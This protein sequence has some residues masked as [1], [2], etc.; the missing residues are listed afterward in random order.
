MNL[1]REPHPLVHDRQT[2]GKLAL[3]LKRNRKQDHTALLDEAAAAFDYASCRDLW[4]NP[5]EMSLLHGTAVWD[6]AT[7]SQ[8]RLLNQLY[9]VA[10]YSQI[11]SA[12]VATIFFNQTAAAGLYG[13][14][15]FRIVGDTLDLE[16]SQE[17]AHIAAFKDV[18]EGTEAELFGRRLFTWP[19]RGPY[20]E[21]MIF[22]DTGRIGSMWKSLQLR[23]FGLL[24]S[25]NA[26]IASQYL[27]V[28]GL[29]TLNG[30]MVQERLSR[31]HSAK[32]EANRAAD[33]IPSKI[34]YFHFM[35]ESYHFNSSTIIGLEVSR[36]LPEP[37]AFEKRVA[38][39]GIAGCQR[40]HGK[41]SVVVRGLFWH[42]PATFRSVYELL[43]SEHFA[44]GRSDALEL[45]RRTFCQ[46]SDG[47]QA[48]AALQRE[49][50]ETYKQYVDP[51]PWLTRQ[52]RDMSVMTRASV[53]TW[54]AT[55][56]A[57]MRRFEAVA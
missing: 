46:D 44:L 11:I 41:F 35:D 56:R 23:A 51:L 50:R 31:Y 32:D 17:R 9:W 52:N 4:W 7:D 53:D 33:S 6:G 8:R 12:E 14:E 48:A 55:N 13:M 21:T 2:S 29:R 57:A 16:S 22:P 24:S 10:Y 34:S 3:N 27:T 5:E 45:M 43:T 40:D 39:M 15:D 26:F 1:P 47:A 30:K 36:C 42:E 20:A 18:S 54:L 38:N 25:G 37:T 19:M 49:A 28:R